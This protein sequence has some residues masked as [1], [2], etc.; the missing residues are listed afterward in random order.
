MAQER[1]TEIRTIEVPASTAWP[2]VLAVGVTLLLFGLVTSLAVSAV[3]AVLL[4]AAAVGWFREVLPRERHEALALEAP[5]PAVAPTSRAVRRLDAGEAPHRARLPV[6]V[7][8][9]SA[10]VRG[11]IAGGVA[12]AALA[13]LHG[14]LNHGS[15]WYT[16]NLLAAAASAELSE[17][18]PETLAAF[19]ATGLVLALVIHATLSL[20]VGLLYGA[21]LPMFPWHPA[22]WGG[23]VAPL[24]WTGL[25]AASLGIIDPALNA[26]IEW[27]W[28]VASQIAFGLLAGI[29]VA[30]SGRVATFQHA[31]P[32]RRAGL[33]TQ[34]DR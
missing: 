24:L 29:V 21:I 16:V 28:F 9:V 11:G 8:P 19:S 3:G 26:R 32:G 7:Y 30:R 15:L 10:G 33:E 31:A 23:I 18:G 1:R 25:I 12:M 5:A 6:L 34:D 27:P 4:V 13:L 20:L 17:A 22:W 14:V 2:M